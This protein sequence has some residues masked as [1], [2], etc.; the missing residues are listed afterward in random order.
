MRLRSPVQAQSTDPGFGKE[1]EPLLRVTDLARAFPAPPTVSGTYT[2][3]T[4]QT[5]SITTSSPHWLD[6]GDDVWMIFTDISSNAPPTTQTYSVTA[7]GPNTL[8]ITAPQLLVGSYGQ[9]N[10]IITA[11]LKWQWPRRWQP[12]LSHL[13]HRWCFQ[14]PLSA[15]PA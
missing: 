12:G 14:W 5:I 10:G 6:N 2:Q 4:N 11:G 15:L 9:T 8:T 1:R 7:T 13:Y 3:T